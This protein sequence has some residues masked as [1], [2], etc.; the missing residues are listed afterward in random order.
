MRLAEAPGRE[1]TLKHLRQ[2]RNQLIVETPNLIHLTSLAHFEAF[3]F[4]SI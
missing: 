4:E 3:D 1:P 2:S